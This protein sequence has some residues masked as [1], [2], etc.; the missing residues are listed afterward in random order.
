MNN[1]DEAQMKADMRSLYRDIGFAGSLQC[2]YEIIWSANVL[3]EVINEE[4]K[5]EKSLDA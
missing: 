1:F 4:I 2:L 3:A 5:K